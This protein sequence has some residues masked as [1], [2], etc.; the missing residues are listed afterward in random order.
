MWIWLNSLK[1][2]HRY[3]RK[4]VISD[5]GGTSWIWVL[6]YFSGSW[7]LRKNMRKFLI[8]LGLPLFGFGTWN[9]ETQ[10]NL[11]KQDFNNQVDLVR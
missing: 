9:F 10:L 4:L 8:F 1:P 11:S 6:R 5:K 2:I 7:I 3:D